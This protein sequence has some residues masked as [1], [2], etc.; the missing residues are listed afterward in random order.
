M[1]AIVRAAVLMPL[2]TIGRSGG[3]CD[4]KWM[5][6]I[7][8]CVCMRMCFVMEREIYLHVH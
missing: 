1:E 7:Q 3:F 2:M 6:P 8:V 4:W 5:K